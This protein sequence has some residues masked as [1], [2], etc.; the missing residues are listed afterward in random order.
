MRG[1][2]P[3]LAA[4]LDEHL[5]L[6]VQ[7]RVAG[8]PLQQVGA[9]GSAVGHGGLH[10]EDHRVGPVSDRLV[11]RPAE[12]GQRGLGDGADVRADPLVHGAEPLCVVAGVGEDEVGPVPQQQPV[13][14]L[15]VDDT[16]I[17]G[18]EYGALR[19]G[20]PQGAGP[21]Q[22]GL[23]RPADQREDDDVVALALDLGEELGAGHLGQPVG[24]HPHLAELARGG[25]GAAAQQV[26]G[27]LV[28]GHETAGGECTPFPS[29][30]GIG[31]Y[32]DAFAFWHAAEAIPQFR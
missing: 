19:R 10:G 9:V 18:D 29:R 27:E 1:V 14:E 15:L 8:R 13:G 12:E 4:Q 23:D 16:H 5:A 28:V 2:L 26:S 24:P 7:S 20:G 3:W 6:R 21:V 31:E 30:V 25:C 17:T 22:D 11:R 32:G